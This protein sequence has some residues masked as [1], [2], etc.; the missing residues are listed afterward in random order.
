MPKA[1]KK[2]L[3]VMVFGTF[4][5]VHKGHGHFFKQAR[6]LG[7]KLVVSIARDINV[8][9]IKGARPWN[10]EKKRLA[11]IK[12]LGIADRVILGDIGN[13]MHHIAKVAPDLIALGYDQRAYTKT[14]RRD[15]RA[16]GLKTRV[17]R[18]KPHRPH[19]YKSSK[20]KAKMLK[21][22]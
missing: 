20:L 21:L 9:K 14:L 5:V 18:L 2:Q 7:K 15:L 6:R 17:V 19:V 8:K 4:D 22:F 16:A 11:A 10:S 12:K 13:Y 1:R 3:T